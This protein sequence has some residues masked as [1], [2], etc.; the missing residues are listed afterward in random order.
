MFE[1]VRLAAILAKTNANDP[2]ALP[3]RQALLMATR[4]GAAALFMEDT[5]GS[6]EVGKRADVMVMDAEPL[7]NTPHFDSDPNAIYSRIVYAGK[8]T[9]VQHVVCNGRWLMRDRALLTLDEGAIKAQAREYARRVD[10]FLSQ[11]EENVLSK[12]LAIGGISQ[13]ESFE[14]QVK[15]RLNDESALDRLLQHPDIEIVKRV[16]YRQYDTYFLF[17]DD[18][19]GRVR[20]REDDSI[21]A[22]GETGSVRSRLTF[23]MPTKVR[24]FQSTVLLSHSRF[25][26]DA[27]QSLRF[28]REYFRPTSERELHK[29]RWRWHIKFHGVL[30]YINL[31]RVL[32]P[33]L[34]GVFIELKSRT[35]SASDA[36]VK[37]DRIGEMLEILGIGAEDIVGND[38]LEMENA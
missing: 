36:E 15:A 24:E 9:D 17:D 2:T 6:L 37:A 12:L 13:S 22:K 10:Q 27:N 21:D 7:H 31:D 18:S 5:T 11:R 30:Y 25:I 14:I 38:Y 35:W 29:D 19:K 3:A 8:S 1:E 32:Q 23:T 34:P 26:A 28:Y 16:H 20:Y 4:Q 33:K